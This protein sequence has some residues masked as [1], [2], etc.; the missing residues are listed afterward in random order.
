MANAQVVDQ[1][2][3]K[4]LMRTLKEFPVK[5]Q[6]NVVVGSTRAGANVVRDEVR[7]RAPKDSGQLAKSVYTRKR[8]TKKGSNAIR[9]VV[10][11]KSAVRKERMFPAVYDLPLRE[12]NKLLAYITEYGTRKRGRRKSKAARPFIRPALTSVGNKPVTAARAY[13]AP[14]FKKLKAKEGFK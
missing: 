2:E 9:F 12:E 10:G 14:R 7:R 5:V 13:F 11:F 1:K 8:R 3:F 4:K 6:K